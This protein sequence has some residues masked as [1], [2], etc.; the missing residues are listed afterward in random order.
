MLVAAPGATTAF[1]PQVPEGLPTVC[2][3][4][5]LI[6]L[7]GHRDADLATLARMAGAIVHRG[8]DDAGFFRAR[9]WALP[10]GG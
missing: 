2:G 6:D 5:G 7:H 1:A 9:V 3:I 8:P 4:A 10:R